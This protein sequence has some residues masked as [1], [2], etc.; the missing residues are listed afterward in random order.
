MR[1]SRIPYLW[2]G[3]GNVD[4]SRET[5][6]VANVRSDHYYRPCIRSV[7]LP[8]PLGRHIICDCMLA[9]GNCVG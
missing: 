6:E 4:P 3:T 2:D 9:S 5:F 7:G 1:N 8:P